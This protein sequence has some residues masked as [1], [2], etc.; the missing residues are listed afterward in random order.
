MVMDIRNNRKNVS[1]VLFRTE[2]KYFRLGFV[3]DDTDDIN[4][5]LGDE[6][7]TARH[8]LFSSVHLAQPDGLISRE[9]QLGQNKTESDVQP[10]K[11][12]GFPLALDSIGFPPLPPLGTSVFAR[13]FSVAAAPFE[14]A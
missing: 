9:L 7:F 6:T 1:L 3:V 5:V 12:S 11:P 8:F 4:K 2:Q 14:T 10:T 13:L